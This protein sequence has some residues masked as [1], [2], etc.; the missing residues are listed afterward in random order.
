[1]SEHRKRVLLDLQD[2]PSL[3]SYLPGA[4]IQAYPNA[5]DLAIRESKFAAFGIPIPAE[6]RYPLECPF[7]IEEILNEDFYGAGLENF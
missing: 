7:S 4:V 2:T 6:N 1:V 5:R 3:K